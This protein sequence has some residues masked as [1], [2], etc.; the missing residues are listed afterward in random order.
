MYKFT[1]APS[2]NESG[3]LGNHSKFLEIFKKAQNG[4]PKELHQGISGILIDYLERKIGS[5]SSDE[6]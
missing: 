5:G 1:Y 6:R 4:K 3:T 2:I